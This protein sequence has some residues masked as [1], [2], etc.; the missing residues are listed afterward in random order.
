LLVG[1]T[2]IGFAPVLVRLADVGPSAIAFYRLLF[3]LPLLW[4]WLILEQAA[5]KSDPERSSQ[6]SVGKRDVAAF[7]IAGLFFTVDLAVWHW[8]LRFTS[9]A[10]STLLANFAPLFVTLGAWFFLRERIA[11]LFLVGML[12]AIGG[13][14]L[15]VSTS[16][17][18]S[19]R[20]VIGDALA[21]AAALFYAGYLL[22]VKNLRNRFSTV[23]IMAWSGLFSTAGLLAAAL[24]SHDRMWPPTRRDWLVLIALALVSHLGG[25][26]LIA[27][28]FGHLPASISSLNLL[29][30]P[31]VAA[32]A[33]WVAL[34]ESLTWPQALGAAV[35]LGGLLIGNRSRR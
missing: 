16:L 28:A 12:I 15:L 35:V 1:A 24:L 23:T 25:Q 29:L 8:S 3:A 33:A 5:N 21:I 22:S 27:Y 11:P 34:G 32:A 19:S 2:G 31:V 26:T 10:N 30:Q 4:L 9:V 14:G 13:A 6:P 20:H 7:A 17:R 18:F